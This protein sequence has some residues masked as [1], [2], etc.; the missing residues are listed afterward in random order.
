[1]T[2]APKPQQKKNDE[3]SL[4]GFLV[5]TAL[6]GGTIWLATFYWLELFNDPH[7]YVYL[8]GKYGGGDVPVIVAVCCLTPTAWLFSWFPVL[9]FK[10]RVKNKR[11]FDGLWIAGIAVAQSA[12]ILA[13][14]LLLAEGDVTA[15]VA[16][17]VGPFCALSMFALV[18]LLR[19]RARPV[20]E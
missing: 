14:S 19:E 13:G 11:F 17:I 12:A 5:T 6:A 16:A 4:T 1:M 3:F 10:P 2:S 15:M 7:G 9:A 20:T 8:P 18:T